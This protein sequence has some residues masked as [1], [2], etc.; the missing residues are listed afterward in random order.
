MRSS[1]PAQVDGPFAVV[2][3]VQRE[4]RVLRAQVA[5]AVA[6]VTSRRQHNR[7]RLQ[8]LQC[9]GCCGV[10]AIEHAPLVS[11]GSMRAAI[12]RALHRND[13]ATCEHW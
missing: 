6:S 7:L 10:E 13:A 4:F 5:D 8:W 1:A 9:R 11:P 12:C 3:V 2:S